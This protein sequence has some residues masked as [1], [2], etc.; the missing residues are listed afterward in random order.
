MMQRSIPIHHENARPNRTAH[1]GLLLLALVTPPLTAS[2]K[3]AAITTDLDRTES[4]L[5]VGTNMGKPMWV[6]PTALTKSPRLSS[7]LWTATH[8]GADTDVAA[9]GRE[10]EPQ[11]AYGSYDIPGANGAYT[12]VYVL[13]YFDDGTGSALYAGGHFATAGDQ[14]VNHIARWEGT[15]WLPLNDFGGTGVNGTVTALEVFDDGAGPALYAGG[16]FTTAGGQTVNHIA[17]WSGTVWLPLTGP[18]TTGMAGGTNTYVSSLIVFDDGNG[19]ALVAA[20]TFETA[21][22]VNVNNIAKWNGTAWSPL[23]AAANSGT[24]G[25]V[26]ALLVY[27]DGSGDALYAAGF[28]SEAGGH[29]VNRIAKWDGS[30]WYPLTGPLGIGLNN[31]AY[32]LTAFDDGSGQALYTGGAFTSAGGMAASRLARWDGSEWSPV[33]GYINNWIAT[34]HGFDDGFGYALYVG[35]SFTTISGQT[36]NGIAK[37]NGGSSWSRLT[38]PAGSGVDGVVRTLI[39]SETHTGD[40]LFAGGSFATAGGTLSERI[41]RWQGCPPVQPT[42]PPDLN[43]DGLLNFFDITRFVQLFNDQDPLADF[44]DNGTLNFF[45]ISTFL[46]ELLAGCP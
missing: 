37:W 14:A 8:G 2:E 29:T 17:R 19:P 42:C 44:D 35:G 30:D 40:Y 3:P 20:G 27:N 10:C 1:C 23:G 43:G 33:T 16:F 39:V 21:G 31:A 45:D 18:S 13:K 34:M 7:G 22:G 15:N 5:K 25:T 12:D 26:R 24:N 9:Q 28:F 46:T 38:G 11:W 32:A 4:F 36:V 6:A 41:A